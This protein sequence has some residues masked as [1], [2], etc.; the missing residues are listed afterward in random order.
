MRKLIGLTAIVVICFFLGNCVQRFVAASQMVP[1]LAFP[2][3]AAAH[4]FAA[5]LQPRFP[6]VPIR[7]QPPVFNGT[8]I[9]IDL[10][11]QWL[12]DSSPEVFLTFDDGPSAE[13]TVQILDVLQR[14]DIKATFFVLGSNVSRL[15]DVV[16]RIVAEGHE[17]A[18]HSHTHPNFLTLTREQ[19]EA[20]IAQSLSLLH[21]YFPEVRIRWFRPPYGKY[22]Q[23]VVDIAHDYGMCI[24]MFNE[25]STDNNSSAGEIARVVLNSRGKIMVFHDGQWP[26][27]GRLSEAEAQLVAGLNRSVGIAKGR[28]AKFMTLSDYFGGFCP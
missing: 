15:P 9:N 19:K 6:Q 11:N 22:D 28:G 4:E 10:I 5:M 16:Q 18:L 12:G 24:A 27:L 20:E 3:S 17:L 21:W 8:D 25:I 2:L 14:H 23:E 7:A 26:P 13:A 1:Q